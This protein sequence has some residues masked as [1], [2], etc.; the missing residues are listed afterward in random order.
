[1]RWSLIFVCGEGRFAGEQAR[2]AAHRQ[3]RF[4]H[5]AVIGS[6]YLGPDRLDMLVLTAGIGEHSSTCA[7]CSAKTRSNRRKNGQGV[8]P[9]KLKHD[10]SGRFRRVGAGVHFAVDRVTVMKYLYQAGIIF[11]FT[12]LGEALTA[13]IS[14]P[15]PAAIWGLLLLFLTLCFKLIRVEQIRECSSFLAVLLPALFVGPAVNLM[16]QAKALL[17]SLPAV[18]AIV[19]VSTALTLLTAGRVTQALIKKENKEE[20][21]D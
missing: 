3:F 5:R 17:G 2:A 21:H 20:K 4:W 12:F 18:I 16:D 11:L 15:I 8:Q 9:Q 10:L 1:M 6:F 13:L 7:G 14:L 19:L